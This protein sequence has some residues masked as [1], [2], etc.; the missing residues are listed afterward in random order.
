M[1]KKIKKL[2]LFIILFLYGK[3]TFSI[4][5]NT[6]VLDA[7]DRKNIDISRFSEAGYVMPGRYLLDINVNG[8]AISPT[9]LEVS[10]IEREI[11]KSNSDRT[12]LSE[13]CLTSKIV[14]LIGLTQESVKKV[15]YWKEGQCAD[16]SQLPGVEIKPETSRGILNINIP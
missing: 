15:T 12:L 2:T 4:E 9:N 14:N 5:F 10:F 13:P 8:Q 3:Q 6:D 1:Y 11:S 16:F 7:H